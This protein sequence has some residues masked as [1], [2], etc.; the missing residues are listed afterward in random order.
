MPT[1]QALALLDAAL[2]ADRPTLVTARLNL[3]MLRQ[4]AA[5]GT[6]P[7]ILR[8]LVPVAAR[9]A[10]SGGGEGLLRQRLVSLPA[11][12]QHALILETVRGHIAAV[13]G[14]DTSEVI[15]PD[16][17]F[18][19]YGFDSLAA[20][21]FRNRLAA[22][23]GQRL[24]ATLVFDYPTVTALAGYLRDKLVPDDAQPAVL[25][26]LEKLES[27]LLAMPSDDDARAQVT[28]RL[29]VLMTKWNEAEQ[30][31]ESKT[32]D[33]IRSATTEEMFEFI[34]KELGRAMR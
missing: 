12:E 17:S 30:A 27:T 25:T 26:E 9:R 2:T 24:P 34:D 5:A 23:T 13:L 18:Q 4:H 31:T 6:L 11:A 20:V 16:R 10:S 7:T 28:A 29:R 33:R 21:E 22:T 14:H 19:E 1:K 3:P 15:G 8:G 32:E